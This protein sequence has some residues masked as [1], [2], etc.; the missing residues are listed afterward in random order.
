MVVERLRVRQCGLVTEELQ[1]PGVVRRQ[2]LLEEQ[3]AEQPREDPDR[4]EEP[5]AARDP[6]VTVGRDTTARHDDVH[7]RVVT[8]T[9]T[10]P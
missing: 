2:K 4:E 7:V 6:A 5:R 10:I 3:P 1:L 9:P 8:P